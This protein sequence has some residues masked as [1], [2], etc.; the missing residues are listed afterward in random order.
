MNSYITML[1]SIV[2][3]YGVPQRSVYGGVNM[4]HIQS[5]Q[6]NSYTYRR[7]KNQIIY[8]NY[9]ENMLENQGAIERGGWQ[10]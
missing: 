8:G 7:L 3:K 10:Q 1:D 2:L 6:G 9:L 4:P 5:E